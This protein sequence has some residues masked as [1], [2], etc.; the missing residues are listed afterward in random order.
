ML[1]ANASSDEDKLRKRKT[2]LTKQLIKIFGFEKKFLIRECVEGLFAQNDLLRMAQRKGAVAVLRRR[3]EERLE[4][5][6]V[7]I[8]DGR[9]DLR[10]GGTDQS[11]SARRSASSG[12]CRGSRRRPSRPSRP[13]RPT[14]ASSTTG[15][16]TRD[17]DRSGP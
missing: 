14:S 5:E 3:I 11:S 12:S 7:K 16:S 4:Q 17:G 1:R 10:K 9:V 8:G 2:E 15:R 13:K 6:R